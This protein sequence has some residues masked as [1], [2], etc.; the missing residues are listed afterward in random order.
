MRS[1]PSVHHIA[2]PVPILLAMLT[3]CL[4]WGWERVAGALAIVFGGL[5]RPG[6]VTSALR[7]DLLLPRDV[8]STIAYALLSIREPKSR[9]TFARH[10]TAK[11]D[12]QDMLTVLD[13]AFGRLRDAEKLWPYSPQTLRQRF[14]SL[15]E[16]L[17]L[18]CESQPGLRSLDLGSLRCG[19][20]TF[21]I[22]STDNSELCRRRG[23]WANHKM[24][25]I[26]V[27]ESMSLQYMKYIS[28]AARQ[29]ILT[30]AHA[31]P[32]VLARATSLHEA[33]IPTSAWY[34][35]LARWKMPCA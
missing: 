21:I 28:E 11:V 3:T 10:Q 33:Q 29:K 24:M 26:Y 15:L 12:A 16:V 19:G 8:G 13:V 27:Q 31:F 2:I 25:E 23:R 9:Y 6:E 32:R 5:L 4:L 35:L 7:K 30:L 17:L 22:Q 18:P 20:A 1:E 14:K 34:F